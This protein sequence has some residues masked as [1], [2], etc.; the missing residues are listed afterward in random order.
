MRERCDPFLLQLEMA[1]EDR[2]NR[3]QDYFVSPEYQPGALASVGEGTDPETD[4]RK[5]L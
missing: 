4:G 1:I 5:R 2:S 3:R